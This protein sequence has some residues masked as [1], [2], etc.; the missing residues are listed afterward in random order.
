VSAL[1]ATYFRQRMNWPRASTARLFL[2]TLITSHM[3]MRSEASDIGVYFELLLANSASQMARDRAP[4][5][6][7]MDFQLPYRLIL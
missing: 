4:P 2:G 6:N 5:T 3:K 7:A 1:C